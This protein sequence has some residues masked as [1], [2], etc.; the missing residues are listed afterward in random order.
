MLFP[1]EIKN[2]LIIYDSF[3][4]FPSS[5]FFILDYHFLR[6]SLV[7]L[8]WFLMG[9]LYF[10]YLNLVDQLNIEVEIMSQFVFWFDLFTD[11]FK[12]DFLDLQRIIMI[13]L[14]DMAVSQISNKRALPDRF[15]I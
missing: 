14:F 3:M 15:G 13:L 11:I 8:S 7:R 2:K 1:I 9:S 6:Q 4:E 12:I 5:L 10:T